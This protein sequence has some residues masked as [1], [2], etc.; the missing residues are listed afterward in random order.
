MNKKYLCKVYKHNL[1]CE[2]MERESDIIKISYVNDYKEYE[3]NRNEIY[4]FKWYCY[5]VYDLEEE[6]EKAVIYNI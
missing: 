2:S 5:E 4:E 3:E 6:K 1:Q